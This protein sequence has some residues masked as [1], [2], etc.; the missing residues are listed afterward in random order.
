MK[1]VFTFHHIEIFI[2][3]FLKIILELLDAQDTIRRL[4]EQLKSLQM[5]KDELEKQQGEL[6]DMIQRME[7]A[8]VTSNIITM[9]M[10]EYFE[11]FFIT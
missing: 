3:Q 6:N 8:K 5:A 2:H 9:F 1:I 10:S 7:D 11:E 4:E